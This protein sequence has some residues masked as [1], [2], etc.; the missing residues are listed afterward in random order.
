MFFP[1][2]TFASIDQQAFT[3]SLTA[4]IMQATG[5]V[6]Y[7]SIVVALSSS[8]SPAGSVV[9]T[10][11]VPYDS[12]QVAIQNAVLAS[13]LSVTVGA[14]SYLATFTLNYGI[15]LDGSVSPNGYAPNCRTCPANTYVCFV[16]VNLE[17]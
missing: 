7:G 3:T 16:F 12:I 14:T 13:Q 17:G 15:C 9:A 8:V 1:S 11:G 5:V 4:A 10:V 2:A 6:S